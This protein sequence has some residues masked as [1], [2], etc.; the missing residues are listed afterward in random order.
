MRIQNQKRRVKRHIVL[1]RQ[2]KKKRKKN[3]ERLTFVGVKREIFHD[4]GQNS[5]SHQNYSLLI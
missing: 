2:K 3:R 1:E 5:F 4:T